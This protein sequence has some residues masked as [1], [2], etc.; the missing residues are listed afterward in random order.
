MPHSRM[1]GFHMTV[2]APPSP[3]GVGGAIRPFRGV[4]VECLSVHGL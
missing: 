2:L 1:I 4:A 3:V